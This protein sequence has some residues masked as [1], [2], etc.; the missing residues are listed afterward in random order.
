MSDQL[1]DYEMFYEEVGS[2]EAPLDYITVDQYNYN[3][4]IE[5]ACLREE[6]VAK[7]AQDQQEHEE[8]DLPSPDQ[9]E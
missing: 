1:D 4:S 7:L 8:L 6:D 9:D 3:E 5:P 2:G